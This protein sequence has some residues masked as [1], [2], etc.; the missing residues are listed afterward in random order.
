MAT[1]RRVLDGR[2]VGGPRRAVVVVDRMEGGRGLPSASSLGVLV[3]G[4]RGLGVFFAVG[5]GAESR[6]VDSSAE[7]TEV[8]GASPASS[9]S[10]SVRGLRA[11]L[12]RCRM[13]GH[14][15]EHQLAA[16][17]A[18]E[19]TREEAQQ[20]SLLP[21][22]PSAQTLKTHLSPRFPSLLRSLSITFG[23]NLTF[24]STIFYSSFSSSFRDPSGRTRS[25]RFS[26]FYI[27]LTSRKFGF[28]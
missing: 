25:R 10:A 23:N 15:R 21:A 12:G 20:S 4:V 3:R 2:P 8:R 6:V 14:R 27:N 26:Q 18:C 5:A 9:V 19:S 28:V 1:K 7:V 24:S 17:L 22:P 13:M 11:D 16:S